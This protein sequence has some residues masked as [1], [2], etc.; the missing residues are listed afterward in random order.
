M[1]ELDFFYFFIFSLLQSF[2]LQN[3]AFSWG[4]LQ[5]SSLGQSFEGFPTFLGAW[6]EGSFIVCKDHL[7]GLCCFILPQDFVPR[8]EHTPGLHHLFPLKAE[9]WIRARFRAAVGGVR[10]TP[11][12][13]NGRRRRKKTQPSCT[14][15]VST[16]IRVLKIKGDAFLGKHRISRTCTQGRFAP[17]PGTN[18][19]CGFEHRNFAAWSFHQFLLQSWRDWGGSGCA[20]GI[21]QATVMFPNQKL[22]FTALEQIQALWALLLGGFLQYFPVQYQATK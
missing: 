8:A 12:L 14:T 17:G 16:F 20:Q 22:G 7:R 3:S 11:I 13:K 2:L 9:E 5:I 19:L 18:F 21:H 1:A 15:L 10:L 6:H 4:C